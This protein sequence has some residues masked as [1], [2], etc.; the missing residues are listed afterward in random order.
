MWPY[1]CYDI[2][3]LDDTKN[4]DTDTDTCHMSYVTCDERK[5]IGQSGGAYPVYF[6]EITKMLSPLC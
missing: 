2:T 6:K 5:K 3:S 1:I 4:T